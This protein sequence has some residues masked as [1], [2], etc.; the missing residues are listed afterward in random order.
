MAPTATLT[1]TDPSLL[2]SQ[3][4]IG[5]AWVNADD[6]AQPRDRRHHW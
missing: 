1:L 2:R 4:F 6:G 3:A 5:G